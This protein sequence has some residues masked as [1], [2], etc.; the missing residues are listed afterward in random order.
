[1]TLV[2]VG[3]TSIAAALE[4][5]AGAIATLYGNIISFFQYFNKTP[6]PPPVVDHD[7]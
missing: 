4:P 5:A 2:A 7:T 6:Y 1:M 3:D